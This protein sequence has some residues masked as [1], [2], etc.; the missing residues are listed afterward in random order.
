M[1]QII[2]FDKEYPDPIGCCSRFG[3][4]PL[5]VAGSPLLTLVITVLYRAGSAQLRNV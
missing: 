4:N 2:S 3:I 1:N 5:S